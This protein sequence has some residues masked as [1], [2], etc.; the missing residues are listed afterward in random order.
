MA[1]YGASPRRS[2]VL[3]YLLPGFLVDGGHMRSA[4]ALTIL[5]GGECQLAVSQAPGIRG[6][7]P[8]MGLPAESSPPMAGL[9][10]VRGE[11]SRRHYSA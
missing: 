3:G 10:P 5:R 6:G 2:G 1:V 4:R 8:S 11:G 7:W 9:E